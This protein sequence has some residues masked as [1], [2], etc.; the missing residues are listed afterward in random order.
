M[1]TKELLSRCA[2]LNIQAYVYDGST[3]P[4]GCDVI[5]VEKN[6]RESNAKFM[7]LKQQ[8]WKIIKGSGYT[9]VKNDEILNAIK[10]PQSG[11]IAL[12]KPVENAII[13]EPVE[14]PVQESVEPEIE[15]PV[16]TTPDP[17]VLFPEEKPK[18]KPYKKQW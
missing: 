3:P 16:G 18:F 10:N 7:P 9:F 15:T 12:E 17:A 5:I 13:E 4:S 8:G 2:D 11:Q 6:T 14:E 1:N